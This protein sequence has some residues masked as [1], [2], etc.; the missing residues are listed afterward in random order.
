MGVKRKSTY[1]TPEKVAAVQRN[2]R[3]YDWA[4]PYLEEAVKQ[5]DVYV[6]LGWEWL[7]HVPAPQT[8]PRSYAVNQQ[9]GCPV[10]GTAHHAYGRWPWLANLLEQPWKLVCPSCESVFPSNDFA[11]Y[12]ESGK[13]QHGVF[14]RELADNRYLRN[15]LYPEQADDWGV[16]DGYGWRDGNGDNWTFVAFYSHWKI[17]CRMIDA[18][19]NVFPST[20]A[21]WEHGG[22]VE[23][24]LLQLR[25]AYLYT[26]ELQYAQAGIVLL[27]RVAD[28]YPAMDCGVFDWQYGFLNSHGS[29]GQGKV[30]GCIWETGLVRSFISAYD[31]FFP[32]MVEEQTE[33]LA[34][35]AE[36]AAYYKL[37]HSKRTMDDIRTNIEDGILRQ[38]YPGVKKVQIKGNNG[39]HQSAL[40]L[41]AIVLDEPGTTEEWLDF[42]LQE[43]KMLRPEEGGWAVTGGNM[44][45]SLVHDVDRDGFG[46][47]AAPLYNNIWVDS[48][49]MVADILHG[50]DR[51]P[52]GDL[53]SNPKFRQML[54]A[55]AGLLMLDRYMPQIGDSDSAGNP[56]TLYKLEM[57]VDVFERTGEPMFAQLAVL[58]NGNSTDGLRGGLFSS[59]PERVLKDIKQVVAVHGPFRLESLNYSGYGFTALRDGIGHS[60][61][62][63]WLYHGRNMGHGHKDSL[64]IGLY[65]FGLDLAPELGYP[66]KC[67]NSHQKTHHW[68]R[69][70]VAHNTVTVDRSKQEGSVVGST[71]LFVG[72][73]EVQVVEAEKPSVYEQ[74][75]VYRRCV[76]MV[77]LDE[78]HSY[79]VDMFQVE[80]GDE[81]LYS[82]H[83][84]E[85]PVLTEGLALVRQKGGTYAGPDVE[86]G[87]PYD[88]D[89]ALP[90][91][92][93]KGSGFHYLT[94]VE[95]DVAPRD[96]FAVDWVVRDTW[97]VLG[98]Q[99]S[100]IATTAATDAQEIHLRLTMLTDVNEVALAD[101]HPSTNRPG[102][103]ERLR[104]LLAKRRPAD[105]KSCFVALLEPYKG[106]RQLRGVTRVKAEARDGSRAGAVVAL[107][108]ERKDGRVDYV[109]HAN[110]PTVDY[111]I[112][113]TIA[114]RGA[115]GLYAERDGEPVYAFLVNGSRIGPTSNPVI[116]GTCPSLTGTVIGF[117]QELSETNWMEVRFTPPLPAGVDL[118]GKHIYVDG[119]GRNP[120]FRICNWEYGSTGDHSVRLD[121]GS[122]T[123][124]EDWANVESADGNPPTYRYAVAGG[125]GIS[126]PLSVEWKR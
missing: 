33:V 53:Y 4:K 120:V 107:R 105:H 51:Y 87:Q 11:S 31:A 113:G 104:Y 94:D 48:F 74:T 35:L 86:F 110:D 75:S 39:M 92:G 108:I 19:G 47:E 44:L 49:K 62:A 28:L 76:I 10:C 82:F 6:G 52:R 116:D 45:H 96:I 119:E 109:I 65:G 90:L 21:P 55:H 91:Q 58:V 71:R 54:R 117:S 125:D 34:F 27:D 41:A 106:E 13:D 43:G 88:A 72:T 122:V 78:A 17:W 56:N 63:V 24:A 38:V 5:A 124:I 95:R 14:H 40:A 36:K 32:A 77:R 83:G 37:P 50:Y 115:V 79:A 15:E 8:V 69:G 7:W 114:F 80:G 68:D 25:D 123:L 121:L 3:V 30:I 23:A 64:N 101:G 98:E 97:G 59:D 1:Y 102:N 73:G 29:T 2:V 16:D 46:D 112:D 61:R 93:Y 99:D 89:P 42:V 103:P 118:T 9:L 57:V 81:H 111:L 22:I 20:D 60:G 85:G 18:G 100:R 26:G 126:I 84:A 12:Y 66:E 67:D 70:T